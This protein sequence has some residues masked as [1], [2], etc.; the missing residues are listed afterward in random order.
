MPDLIGQRLG[1][2][3]ILEQIGK[4]GMATVYKAEQTSLQRTVAVKVLPAYF[5]HDDTFRERF[6]QEARA[7]GNLNHPHILAVYDFGQTDELAYIVMEYVKGGTLG[8]TMGRPLSMDYTARII[9]QIG[10][11]LDYAHRNGVIHRDVK[12]GNIML[13]DDG[14]TALLADFGLAKMAESKSALTRS[15]VGVGT[16][17]YLSPEQGQGLKVDWR[18]DLYSLGVVMYEMLTGHIP[19]EAETP[20]AVI[21]KHISEPL[22]HARAL[23]PSLPPA[24]DNV[25]LKALAK[26]PADRFQSGAEMASAIRQVAQDNALTVPSLPMSKPP[27]S[28][29]RSTPPPPVPET[30]N[31]AALAGAHTAPFATPPAVGAATIG[32]SAPA[33]AA[34]VQ[35]AGA[36]GGRSMLP[37]LLGG[38]L[39]ILL[40]A[41]GGFALFA[42]G[43]TPAATPTAVAIALATAQPSSTL[44]PPVTPTPSPT[45][46]PSA[47]G[48]P[49]TATPSAT[50]SATATT[51]PTATPPPPTDTPVPIVIPN[52]ATPRPPTNTPLPPTN[53][54]VPAPQFSGQLAIPMCPSPAPCG[55]RSQVINMYRLDG[56]K[57]R[58]I[59]AATEPSYQVD[60]KRLVFSSFA[61]SGTAGKR[62]NGIYYF[63]YDNGRDDNIFTGSPYPIDSYP[64]YMSGGILFVTTRF[65]DHR[66]M[67]QGNAGGDELPC[68]HGGPCNVG[69]DPVRII[70]NARWPAFSEASGLIAF[71][72]C[73]G[74]CGIWT[75][76]Q[77]GCDFNGRGCTQIA[78]GGSDTAPNWAPDGSRLVFGSH[79]DGTYEIYTVAPNGAGRTRLTKAAGSNVAPAWSPDGLWIAFLSDRSGQ[80]AVWA[81]KPDGSNPTKVFDLGSALFEPAARRM[82]WAP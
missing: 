27:E 17:E 29:M 42:N 70:K 64:V 47:T 22:P 6:F 59:G 24:I 14:Q 71:A 78:K 10:S 51:M 54:P 43:N 3:I 31:V 4:G 69:L 1:Q 18:T 33:G 20:L 65:D 44:V 16:P 75:G 77:G 19:F 12:P 76:G 36:A 58:T 23:N 79:E 48:V 50:E 56:T 60:G 74:G 39:L 61:S 52:T 68:D 8:Q 25:M 49:A 26:D 63:D 11:A 2:Y 28:L 53:T 5:A 40:A 13:R 34:T 7:V 73:F 35:P 46:Q 30:G 21:I 55:E 80:W 66:L 45:P 72:G 37:V 9:E 15:G 62:S 38:L 32:Y 82:S 81:M 57:I 67:S 41:G